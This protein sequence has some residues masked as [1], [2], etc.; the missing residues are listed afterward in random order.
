[1]SERGVLVDTSIDISNSKGQT[2]T[3][4]K[5]YYSLL[6]VIKGEIST[7][8]ES[9][10]RTIKKSLAYRGVVGYYYKGV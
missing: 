9:N 3:L 10:V 7:R 4:Y 6:I 8:I 2:M 1:M 5:Y